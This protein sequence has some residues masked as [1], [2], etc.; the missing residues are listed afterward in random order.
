MY[1]LHTVSAGTDRNTYTALIERPGGRRPFGKP[2][3]RW[4]DKIKIEQN[5]R[6]MIVNCIHLSLD[7]DYQ[8]QT[9]ANTLIN[10]RN[11]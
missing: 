8:Q 5:K 1:V 9:L 6:P 2:T 3:R 11:P 4:E 7:S 10:F